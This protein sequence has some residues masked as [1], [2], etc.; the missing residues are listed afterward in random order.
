MRLFHK[1]KN[2][3]AESIFRD[4]FRDSEVVEAGQKFEGVQL[5]DD[6]IGWNPNSDGSNLLLAIEIPADAISGYEWGTERQH[7]WLTG[8]ETREF[9]VPASVVNYYGP[10]VVEDVDLLGGLLDDIDLSGI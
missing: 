6:P 1:T 7:H 2:Q 8:M 4:G 9:L 5:F 10:P 3:N